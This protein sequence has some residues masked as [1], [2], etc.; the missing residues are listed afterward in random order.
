M[1]SLILTAFTMLFSLSVF[2]EPVCDFPYDLSEDEGV[3]DLRTVVVT[4]SSRLTSL[5]KTQI[6]ITA[7]HYA[8]RVPRTMT[9]DMAIESLRGNSEA[10]DLYYRVFRFKNTLYTMVEYYPGGNSFGLV[11]KGTEIVAERTDGDLNC[12]GF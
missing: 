3:R 10:G 1:K 8:A 4:D 9:I 6:I 11:F 12:T 2:A 5:Q 7:K